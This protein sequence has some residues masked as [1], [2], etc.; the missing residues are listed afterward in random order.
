MYSGAL[1]TVR[2]MMGVARLAINAGDLAH[3]RVLV[4]R[5]HHMGCNRIR[6]GQ[7]GPPVEADRVLFIQCLVQRC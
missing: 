3:V 1:P 4:R 6:M 7:M 2:G 5:G